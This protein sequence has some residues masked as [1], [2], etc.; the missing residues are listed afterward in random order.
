MKPIKILYIDDNI[1]TSLS[2]YLD[3]FRYSDYTIFTKDIKYNPSSGYESLIFNPHIS[4]ANIIVI[5][6][7]L[8]ENNNTGTEKF[9]G[10]EFKVIFKKAYP[11][12]EVIVIT[13]NE[14]DEQLDIVSKYQAN[15]EVSP[16]QFYQQKLEKHLMRSI[17]NVDV[18]RK[19]AEKLFNNKYIEE[20]IKEKIFNSLRGENIYDDLSKN[21]IDEIIRVFQEFQRELD[22]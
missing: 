14:I 5:D 6:S 11:F 17:D 9:T 3:K 12:I 1:D 10:E 18:N 4:E 2:K 20:V 13:Q 8:F 19:L 16:E 15:D 22:E 7:H 21:D